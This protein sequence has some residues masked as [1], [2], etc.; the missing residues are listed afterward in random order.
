[1]YTITANKTTVDLHKERLT[2]NGCTNPGMFDFV[3]GKV[4]EP[5]SRKKR[6]LKQPFSR[7]MNYHRMLSMAYT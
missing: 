6:S 2:F 7:M 5:T 3:H 4:N 1:M